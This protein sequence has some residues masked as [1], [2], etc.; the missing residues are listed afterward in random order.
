MRSTRRQ[1]RAAVVV[2]P[3][4]ARRAVVSTT[5]LVAT[6]TRPENQ[7][8]KPRRP[9]DASCMR[10]AERPEAPAEFERGRSASVSWPAWL[11]FV[12]PFVVL[13][14]FLGISRITANDRNNGVV[15]AAEKESAAQLIPVEYQAAPFAYLGTVTSIRH[16]SMSS[17]HE[18]RNDESIGGR[19]EVT[20]SVLGDLRKPGK[21][22]AAGVD[23]IKVNCLVRPEVLKGERVV[24][25]AEPSS[26]D[27]RLWGDVSSLP[28]PR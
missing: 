1:S 3:E 16:T 21:E 6:R 11:A 25:Y 14:L 17:D 7:V 19:W 2:V 8:K 5:E 22:T 10:T 15:S 27:H 20:V 28:P 18:L 13:A 12:A 24:A 23:P 26:I 4:L 9:V